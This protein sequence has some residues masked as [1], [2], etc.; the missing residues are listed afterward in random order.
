MVE[1]AMADALAEALTRVDELK[2]SANEAFKEK[3][4]QAADELYTKA[5]D[6][7]AGKDRADEELKKALAVLFANRSFTRLRLEEYGWAIADASRAV[8]ANPNYIKGYYRRGSANYALGKYQDALKDFRYVA[9]ASP[10]DRDAAA[11]LKECE[12]I[13]KQ[14]AFAR[15]IEAEEPKS[16]L[17]SL[18]LGAI[19]VE[20][21]YDGPRFPADGSLTLDWV[22]QLMDYFRQQQKLHRKYA[23]QLLI[24]AK[25]HF[26]QLETVVT[27]PVH[28][29][30]VITVCGDTHGQFYDLMS[31]FKMN[32]LPS[33]ENPYL[34]NG[35]FVDRG[36]FSVEVIFTLLAFKVYDPECM[37]LTRGNHESENM[38]RIYGFEG[39]VKAKHGERLFK[40]F[41]EVFRAMPLAYVL[42]GSSVS[43]GKRAFVLH[44]GLFSR[45]GVKLE[46]LR[47]INRFK[48]PDSGLM[49]E[50]LWSDPQKETGWGTSK[51]G[52]GASFGPDV[53][54]RFLE[55][56]HLDL[57]VRSHEL[58]EE[59]Y[60]VEADGRLITV[61]SAPNYCDQMGNR[62]AFIRF[63]SDM[64]PDIHQFAA[65]P[66]PDVRP[67]AYAANANLMG[68]A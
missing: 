27:Y 56:N 62:G 43:G 18:D 5:I 64:S 20:S 13:V 37:H 7:L 53:T 54:R 8:K 3:K 51:R 17:E 4:F 52:I 9:R 30:K 22:K 26:E 6:A 28:E 1:G 50:M 12:R 42:D 65:V 49:A 38:N 33:A 61:F 58:K 24:A 35:D 66:H 40:L 67:M 25:H 60:E 19:E 46:E 63:K 55:D 68:L 39:E 2:A 41:S 14:E 34:F 45:D 29:G 59:G 15:A 16:V 11:K 57:V 21:S 23:F 47:K 44:G 31:I 36:S 32:G 10:R 48:E